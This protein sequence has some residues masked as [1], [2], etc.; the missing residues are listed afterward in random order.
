M[1]VKTPTMKHY[2]LVIADYM[3]GFSTEAFSLF[4]LLLQNWAETVNI[5][6]TKKIG[7][8]TEQSV[9]SFLIFMFIR[10]NT[11]QF[12]VKAE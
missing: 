6:H 9:L 8:C 1:T 5:M 7:P 11:K 2:P 3:M 10:D 4:A 12:H